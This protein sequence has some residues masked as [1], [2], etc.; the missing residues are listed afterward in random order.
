MQ[1]R[2][3]DGGWE[4]LSDDRAIH[5]ACQVMRDL[6]RPDRAAEKKSGFSKDKDGVADGEDV[7]EDKEEE[8]DGK[9]EEES[10][11]GNDSME[12]ATATEATAVEEAVMATEQVLDKAL[13]DAVPGHP[14]GEEET[15]EEEKEQVEMM[16]V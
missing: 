6:N 1:P 13:A 3:L 16:Q 4:E 10:A 2:G 8:G 5:K 9:R 12:V 7:D 15:P 11:E 14:S